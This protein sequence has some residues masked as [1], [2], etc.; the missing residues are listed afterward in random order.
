[1]GLHSMLQTLNR[2]VGN[3]GSADQPLHL[4]CWLLSSKH[5]KDDDGHHP[6]ACLRSYT[7]Y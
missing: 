3:Y 2:A 6:L 5:T 7:A 1:M 4:S